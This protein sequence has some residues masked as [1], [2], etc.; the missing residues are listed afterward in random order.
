M[1]LYSSVPSTILGIHLGSWNISPVD[2]DYCIQLRNINIGGN[3]IDFI[4]QIYDV[5]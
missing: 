3:Y 2:K 4:Y 1:Y 5:K